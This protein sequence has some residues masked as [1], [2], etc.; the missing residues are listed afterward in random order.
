M[1]R[2]IHTTLASPKDPTC[3]H[4]DTEPR[5]VNRNRSFQA[6]LP[7]TK[8]SYIENRTA[9]ILRAVAGFTQDVLNSNKVKMAIADYIT[10]EMKDK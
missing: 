4:T 9:G 5:P 7:E 2:L 8:W 10:N 3:L 1:P 6:S